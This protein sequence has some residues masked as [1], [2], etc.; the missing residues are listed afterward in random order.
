MNWTILSELTDIFKE[1]YPE[2]RNEIF[3]AKLR[4]GADSIFE[5]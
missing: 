2:C 3:A 1:I 5:I 4:A